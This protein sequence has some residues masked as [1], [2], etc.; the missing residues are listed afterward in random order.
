MSKWNACLSSMAKRKQ[1]ET[2]LWLKPFTSKSSKYAAFK[3]LS[4]RKGCKTSFNYILN[5]HFPNS[6]SSSQNTHE[7]V[8]MW[9]QCGTLKKISQGYVFT[10]LSQ[11]LLSY[12]TACC[13]I[14]SSCQWRYQNWDWDGYLS[15]FIFA[16]RLCPVPDQLGQKYSSLETC[17][18]E[19][20]Y[21]PCYFAEAS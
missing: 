3:L 14:S 2:Q 7:Q 21:R 13:S 9:A 16:F 12:R 8:W 20:M 15:F 11:H 18:C 5:I 10:L 6:T 19:H 17:V 4:W 1:S